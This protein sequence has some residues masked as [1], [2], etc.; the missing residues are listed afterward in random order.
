MATWSVG[1]LLIS[2]HAALSAQT[3]TALWTPAESK[4][5]LRY[6]QRG[7]CVAGADC[8]VVNS[9]SNKCLLLS[10]HSK[11]HSGHLQRAFFSRATHNRAHYW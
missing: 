8:G 7:A 6:A 2:V 1:L 3:Q 11:L 10:L 5:F 9:W 4:I